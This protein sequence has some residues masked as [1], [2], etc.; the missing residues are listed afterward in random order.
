MDVL[1]V[2]FAGGLFVQAAL[3]VKACEW[4]VSEPD[5]DEEPSDER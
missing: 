3:Y 1:F 4:L 2:V 5:V